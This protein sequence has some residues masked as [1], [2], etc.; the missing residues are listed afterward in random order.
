MGEPFFIARLTSWA[1]AFYP[2]GRGK[3]IF[4]RSRHDSRKSDQDRRVN[5]TQDVCGRVLEN[6]RGFHEPIEFGVP[7]LERFF[8]RGSDPV[9]QL[10]ARTTYFEIGRRAFFTK[11]RKSPG[12]RC[13]APGSE[14]GQ[15]L[16]SHSCRRRMRGTRRRK[17]VEVA[18]RQTAGR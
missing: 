13:F 18:A 10:G 4:L 6:F 14:T 7:R 1:F 12:C 9:N 5:R 3:K 11:L 17:V 8:E 15:A 2:A 16:D